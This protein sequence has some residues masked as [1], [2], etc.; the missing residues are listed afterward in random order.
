MEFY[1]KIGSFFPRNIAD[2]VSRQLDYVG[3]E[4]EDK[5]FLGF[6]ILFG[7]GLSFAIALNVS[8]LLNFPIVIAFFFF[9]ISFFGI[10]WYWL[11]SVSESKGRFVEKILPD[12]LEFIASN[13]KA[14]LTTER[15]LMESARPEFGPL[16][17]EL[18]SA[19][20][21]VLLGSR[22]DTALID[23]TKKIK[24]ETLDRTVWLISQ[25]LRSGGQIADLL[26]E[27]GNDLRD[28]NNV[29]EE[30]KANVSIY[31]ILILFTAAIG[32]PMLFGVSNFIVGILGDQM[33]KISISQQQFSEYQSKSKLGK[34]IGIP[35]STISK[36]FVNFFSLIAL[37]VTSI[38]AG[39]TVGVINSG[40]EADG[41]KYIPILLIVSIVFFFAIKAVLSVAFGSIG[42]TMG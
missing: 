9:L 35:T 40:K 37:A 32:A 16:G 12:A 31:V 42:T 3:I 22:L 26:L 19:S 13:I 17:K 27:M 23:I 21:A 15:A 28:E 18:K 8:I 7:I 25:G 34:F 36:D 10:I 41:V 6:I 14:G 2:Y 1:K 38:F 33:G 20:R 39:L 30:N 4:M 11:Y 29:K 5:K 24:S